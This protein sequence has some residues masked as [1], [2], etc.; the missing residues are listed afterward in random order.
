[1][2]KKILFLL[3]IGML[4][5]S[6]TINAHKATERYI[7]IGYSIDKSQRHTYMGTVTSYDAS[8]KVLTVSGP[9]GKQEVRLDADT[10][11][12]LDRSS[13]KKATLDGQD[14]DLKV[15][16]RVE[17]KYVDPNKKMKAE[18]IKIE[19]IK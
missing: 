1:M 3:M 11:I 18:W 15:N 8:D 6:T 16:R 17:V 14:S 4:L 2:C 13:I 19:I 10:K 9:A 12:W 7:P 5:G